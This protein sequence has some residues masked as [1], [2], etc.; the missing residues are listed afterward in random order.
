[1]ASGIPYAA[2]PTHVSVETTRPNTVE[3]TQYLRTPCANDFSARTSTGSWRCTSRSRR[4]SKSTESTTMNSSTVMTITNSDTAPL[5][6]NSSDPTTLTTL[7]GLIDLSWSMIWVLVTPNWAARFSASSYMVWN[8]PLYWG[9]S[10]TNSDAAQPMTQ[11]SRPMM[12]I[13]S[14]PD[15]IA[16]ST[17]GTR[18][19]RNRCTGQTTIMR[20][21]A[22]KNGPT[23]R[24]SCE[25]P[26]RSTTTAA[27]PTASR[28][29]RC[30]PCSGAAAG[31]SMPVM[32]PWCRTEREYASLAPGER[33]SRYLLWR[34]TGGVQARC[35]HP[36]MT[37]MG[38]QS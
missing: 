5:T 32:C 29:A 38:A 35:P 1:M 12:T 36:L 28:R 3:V 22:R 24:D 4:A 21:S 20:F 30:G 14:S 7:L 6:F 18:R 31:M 33:P 34:G 27:A 9:I 19:E 10:C 25:R 16:A 13:A 2:R 11:N 15:T 8:C 26:S 17:F 23:I 37:S